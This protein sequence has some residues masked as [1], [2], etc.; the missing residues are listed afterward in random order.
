MFC[1]F[2]IQKLLESARN[3]LGYLRMVTP[4]RPDRGSSESS[5][6]GGRYRIVY[7]DGQAVVDGENEPMAGRKAVSNWHGGNLDPDSVTRHKSQLSRMGF[8]DN[9]HAKGFF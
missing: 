1:F 6:G 7:K 9:A 3:S 2:R 4:R 8:R 5:D